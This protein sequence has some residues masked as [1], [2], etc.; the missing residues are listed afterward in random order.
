M[1]IGLA[2]K[3][4]N[5]RSISK[6]KRKKTQKEKKLHILD[7]DNV[8]GLG[9]THNVNNPGVW[10]EGKEANIIFKFKH[11]E[12]KDYILRFKIRS[13]MTDFKDKLD[14]DIKFNGKLVKKMF[15]Q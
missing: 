12:F 11:N 3:I 7:K 4:M 1:I 9:W 6:M 8:V 5:L 13:V 10:T 15:L 14:V 2:T